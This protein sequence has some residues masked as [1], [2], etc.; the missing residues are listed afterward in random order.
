M[1]NKKYM[2]PKTDS[3]IIC[4]HFKQ[5]CVFFRDTKLSAC[6]QSFSF[7]HEILLSCARIFYDCATLFCYQERMLFNNSCHY[8]CPHKN[9]QCF[10][11][12]HCIHCHSWCIRCHCYQTSWEINGERFVDMALKLKQTTKWFW[13]TLKSMLSIETKIPD[14]V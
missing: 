4:N 3:T 1:N 10:Y 6:N 5:N 2:K 12:S 14:A 13:F 7:L 9:G 8:W 11:C